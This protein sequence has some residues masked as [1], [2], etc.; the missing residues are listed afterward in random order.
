MPDD[1]KQNRKIMPVLS[2]VIAV[3]AALL[4]II[5]STVVIMA[6]KGM[7]VHKLATVYE[8]HHM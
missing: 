5:L 8:S 2:A 3:V 4:L 7:I 6:L 1:L